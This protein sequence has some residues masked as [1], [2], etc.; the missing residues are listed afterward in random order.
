MI[1]SWMLDECTTNQDY[2]KWLLLATFYNITWTKT[3]GMLWRMTYPKQVSSWFLWY[4]GINANQETGQQLCKLLEYCYKT[5]KCTGMVLLCR[6]IHI[7][8]SSTWTWT[9]P[10]RDKGIAQSPADN[11]KMKPGNHDTV[12]KYT[13]LKVA[14]DT[15][16]VRLSRKERQAN[17]APAKH[18]P[19]KRR[20]LFLRNNLG[21]M[22]TVLFQ[23]SSLLK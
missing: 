5:Q 2:E 13:L 12:A 6:I 15:L 8:V 21:Y 9:Y 11:R 10:K 19:K 3:I 16:L 7:I 23:D 20:K 14:A 1:I 18:T 4:T 22:Y 17:R